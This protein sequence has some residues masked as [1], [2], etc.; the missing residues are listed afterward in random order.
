MKDINKNSTTKVITSEGTTESTAIKS[1]IR[2]GDSLNFRG[3]NYST[4]ENGRMMQSLSG[5]M[6]P[7]YKE[8]SIYLIS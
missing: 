7:I 1:G 2:Q 8:S 3:T 6:W 5:I 4:N